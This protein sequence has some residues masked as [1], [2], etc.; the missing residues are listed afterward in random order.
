MDVPSSTHSWKWHGSYAFYGKYSTS[1]YS[2]K[3]K[4]PFSNTFFL[5]SLP[6]SSCLVCFL[7]IFLVYFLEHR[8][9]FSLTYA[10]MLLGHTKLFSAHL[11]L[12]W[13]GHWSPGDVLYLFGHWS[14]AVLHLSWRR[15]SPSRV[16]TK[17]KHIKCNSMY[18]QFIARRH[19]RVKTLPLSCLY[20]IVTQDSSPYL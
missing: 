12:H 13:P 9:C 1:M 11:N 4:V 8:K 20:L 14:E 3:W 19:C 2:G 5:A 17:N 18:Q 6:S 15:P 16:C 10:Y 7:V